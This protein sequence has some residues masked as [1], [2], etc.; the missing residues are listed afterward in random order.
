MQ[1]ATLEIKKRGVDIDPEKL[2]RDLKLRGDNAATLLITR[3]AGRATAI[4]AMRLHLA[5]P[6]SSSNHRNTASSQTRSEY[7]QRSR[8]YHEVTLC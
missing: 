3:I 1:S 2:R 4:L 7:S 6:Q 5:A 8:T